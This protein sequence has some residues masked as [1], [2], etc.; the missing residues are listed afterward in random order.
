MSEIS[1]Q[2]ALHYQNL[3]NEDILKPLHTIVKILLHIMKILPDIIKN[4]FGT[5]NSCLI[6]S[7]MTM[8]SKSCLL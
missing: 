7:N 3:Y 4:I 6:W 5:K 8:L 2:L 1:I